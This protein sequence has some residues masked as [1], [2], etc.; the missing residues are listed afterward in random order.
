MAIEVLIPFGF[1]DLR[2]RLVPE[3]INLCS[4]IVTLLQVPSAL[5]LGKLAGDTVGNV[6]AKRS[7][8]EA[9]HLANLALRLS[10]KQS[11][12]NAFAHFCVAADYATAFRSRGIALQST[13]SRF[14]PR[15]EI[16]AYPLGQPTTM[17]ARVMM[18]RQQSCENGLSAKRLV[19][20][21]YGC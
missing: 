19:P 11:A 7:V 10:V 6:P 18:N 8:G 5:G 20:T 3:I 15:T 12:E 14:V 17:C 16:E 4:E 9:K 13:M 21:Q 2:N 1:L